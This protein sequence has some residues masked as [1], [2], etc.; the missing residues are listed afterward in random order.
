MNLR[1]VIDGQNSPRYLDEPLSLGLAP[2]E[3]AL[4]MKA[5]EAAQAEIVRER[6][7]E[8]FEAERRSVHQPA[9]SARATKADAFARVAEAALAS[10]AAGTRGSG[11]DTHQVVVHVDADALTSRPRGELHNGPGLLPGTIRRICCDASLVA[12]VERDGEALSVGRKTR[13]IPPA[14]RRALKARDAGCRFP[15]CSADR[16]IDA[17]HIQ[18]W[19][20]GGETRLDNLVSL[21]RHHH[22]LLHEGGFGVLAK[23]DGTVVFRRPNGRRLEAAP[24]LPGAEPGGEGR[25]PAPATPPDPFNRLAPCSAGE[26]NERLDLDHTLFCLLQPSRGVPRNTTAVGSVRSESEP[27]AAPVGQPP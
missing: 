13:S 4:V 8:A 16:F 12:S 5:L 26:N 10:G 2:E 1:G 25:S 18:H 17:H 27:R 24:Q 14:I 11:G 3:G 20:D 19:A 23:A 22:R 6:S 21:C 15:G 7:R 9:P